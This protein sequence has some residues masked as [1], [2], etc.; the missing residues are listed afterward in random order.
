MAIGAWGL[1]AA[2]R[3]G[4]ARRALLPRHALDGLRSDQVRAAAAAPARRRARRRQRADRGGDVPRDS[5]RHDPRRQRSCSWTRARL[6]SARAAWPRRCTGWIDVAPDS[7]R[8]R[9]PRDRDA[10]RPRVAA[11]H[12]RGGPPRGQPPGAARCRSSRSRGSGCSARPSSRVCRCSPRTCS[13]ADE[14][15]VTLMLALFAVGVGLGSVLAERLLH[16]EV[17]AR[18]VPLAAMRHG[19]LR[20]RSALRQRRPARRR[21]AR[22]PCRCS[23]RSRAAGASWSI[24]SRLAMAGGLFTVPLYAI[25]QHESE[26]AHRARVIAANNIINALAMTVGARG[27][28]GAPR[29]A[30]STM[31]ALFAWCGIATLP[32]ALAA[33]WILRHALVKGVVRAVLRVLYRVEVHGHRA[34]ARRAAACGDRRQPRVVPRRPAARRVPAGRADLRRRHARSRRNGGRGRSSRSSTRCRSI[35]PTRSRSGR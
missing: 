28:R 19:V 33:A 4:A 6:S 9:R 1:C 2:E 34:R 7:R 13:F 22:R 3:A 20:R 31:G 8:R 10:P 15:V 26:P 17:S 14:Q 30:A 5:A 16:G 25:L 32:V 29:R 18:Y 35:P 12:H 24:S 23:S 21:R 27:L 11:R